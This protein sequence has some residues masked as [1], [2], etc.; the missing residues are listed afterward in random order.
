VMR[1]LWFSSF[2]PPSEATPDNMAERNTVVSTITARMDTVGE[3]F[4]E[5]EA[6]YGFKRPFLKMDT[7]GFDLK[8]LQG[9]LPR[10][11]RFLGLQ[12]ELGIVPIYSGMPD[13]KEA[14]AE[15]QK[16]GFALCAFFPVS[17]DAQMRA[18]ELDVVMVRNDI[19]D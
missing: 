4:D 11:D 13:W 18:V 12:S 9:A 3:R 2:L 17:G 7:Q 16:A 1:K 8:V 6:T 5:L 10:I 14:L 19:A 15:Y